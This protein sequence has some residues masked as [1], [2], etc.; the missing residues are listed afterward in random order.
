M[1]GSKTC[2]AN[3]GSQNGNA[4]EGD[5]EDG[6]SGGMAQSQQVTCLLSVQSS[7][8][9]AGSPVTVSLAGNATYTRVQYVSGCQSAPAITMNATSFSFSIPSGGCFGPIVVGETLAT[10]GQG[11]GTL[12]QMVSVG[13]TN[14]ETQTFTA[15]D[16]NGNT[17]MLPQ[18]GQNQGGEGDNGDHG[19]QGGTFRADAVSSVSIS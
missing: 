5:H 9:L 8:A 6:G 12:T 3:G 14:A 10:T 4:D 11:G 16:Q 15:T 2:S 13:G 19:D 18:T 17:F 1:T 7:Q